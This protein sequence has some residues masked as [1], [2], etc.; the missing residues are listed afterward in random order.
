MTIVWEKS[1][2]ILKWSLCFIRAQFNHSQALFHP[3]AFNGRELGF[4]P[5]INRVHNFILRVGL[6]P[7]SDIQSSLYANAQ[8]LV[9]V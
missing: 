5:E 2:N 7:L 1:V 4:P 9:P 8:E 6:A 3:I